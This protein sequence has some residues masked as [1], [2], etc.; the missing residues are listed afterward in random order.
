MQGKKLENLIAQ[1]TT[2]S[3]IIN[4][5]FDFKNFVLLSFFRLVY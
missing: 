1:F 2:A 4:E 3:V 5:M